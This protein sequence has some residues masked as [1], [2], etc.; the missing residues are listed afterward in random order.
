MILY[1]CLEIMKVGKIHY[2]EGLV[3]DRKGYITKYLARQ[4]V[5]DLP[6]LRMKGWD[7]NSGFILGL[8]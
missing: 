8:A 5:L 1:W 2:L 4:E 3:H 7:E 6:G